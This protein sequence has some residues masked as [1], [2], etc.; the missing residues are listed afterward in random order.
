M[1]G[2]EELEVHA[3]GAIEEG[4]VLGDVRADGVPVE[5]RN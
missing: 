2:G 1:E 3:E 5:D 4:L